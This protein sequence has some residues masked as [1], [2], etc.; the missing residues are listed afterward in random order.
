[1]NKIF[2]TLKNHRTG[3]ATAVSELQTGRTKGSGLSTTVL[4][5]ALLLALTDGAYAMQPWTGGADVS[6]THSNWNDH[7][8]THVGSGFAFGNTKLEFAAKTYGEEVQV[9][10]GDYAFKFDGLGEEDAPVVKLDLDDP[11]SLSVFEQSQGFDQALVHTTKLKIVSKPVS[12]S[13]NSMNGIDANIFEQLVEQN[14]E[15]VARGRYIIG[16]RAQ[17]LNSL[18]GKKWENHDSGIM[19]DSTTFYTATVL[20]ELDIYNGKTLELGVSGAQNW[21]AHL[22]GEG[23]VAYVGDTENKAENVV[24]IKQLYESHKPSEAADDRLH[25]AN[26]YDGATTVKNVTLNLERETSL[27]SSGI[28][29]ADNADIVEVNQGALGKLTEID[30]TNT[31]LKTAG[32]PLVVLGDATFAGANVLGVT[33]SFEVE[34]V[35]DVKS[36]SLTTGKAAFKAGTLELGDKLGGA[37]LTASSVKV[38]GNS[39]VSGTNTVNASAF[40]TNSLLLNET[41]A[42]TATG[43]VTATSADL[44]GGWISAETLSIDALA[45]SGANT[46]STENGATVTGDVNLANGVSLDVNRGKFAAGANVTVASGAKLHV[47][48]ALTVEETLTLVSSDFKK[49]D[50]NFVVVGTLKVGEKLAFEGNSFEDGVYAFGTSTSALNSAYDVSLTNANVEYESQL[51]GVGKT[52]LNQAHLTLAN[53]NASSLGKVVEMT[54]PSGSGKSRNLLT[55]TSENGF[56][57]IGGNF[58]VKGASPEDVIELSGSG[59]VTFSQSSPFG[60]ENEKY[61]GWIRMTG[62]SLDLTQTLDP[63]LSFS[64]GTGGTIALSGDQ[65]ITLKRLGWAKPTDEN[66]GMLDLSSFDFSNLASDEAAIS[67]DGLTVDGNGVIKLDQSAVSGLSTSGGSDGESIFDAANKADGKIKV[68]ATKSPTAQSGRIDVVLD[69]VSGSASALEGFFNADGTYTTDS[70]AAAAKGTWNYGTAFEDDGLYV[71]H[72]LTEVELLASQWLKLNLNTNETLGVV[73]TGSGTLEKSG[74]GELYLSNRDNTLSGE[75]RVAD[76]TLHAD[77]GALGS[78]GKKDGP[79]SLQ[80]ATNGTFLLTGEGTQYLKTLTSDGT[81]ELQTGDPDGSLTLAVFGKDSESAIGENSHLYGTESAELAVTEGATLR[82]KDLAN[83][84]SDYDGTIDV[85]GESYLELVGVRS[86]NAPADLSLVTGAGTVVLQ[87]RAT[88]TTK[89]GFTGTMQV[90][91]GGD[92]T[93]TKDANT[94]DAVLGMTAGKIASEGEHTFKEINFTGGTIHLGNYEAGDEKTS[95]MLHATGN[96]KLHDVTLEVSPDYSET[97]IDAT[98]ILTLDNTAGKTTLLL[99]GASVDSQNVTVNGI[100]DEGHES[101]LYQNGTKIG[102]ID[103]LLT[104]QIDETSVGVKAVANQINLTGTLELSVA[105]GMQGEDSTLDLI[106]NGKEPRSTV[107][108]TGGSV[109]LKQANSYGKLVVAEGAGVVLGNDQTLAAGGEVNGQVQTGDHNLVVTGGTLEV[110]KSANGDIGI[111]LD[112][113]ENG[114][115]ELL[116]ANRTDNSDVFGAT[117]KAENGAK[118]TFDNSRGK[119]A[120]A[121][122][123]AEYELRNGSAVSFKGVAANF[124]ADTLAV[125]SG[126]SAYYLFDG[127]ASSV[128]LSNVSGEG[129]VM[130]SYGQKGGMFDLTAVNGDFTGAIGVRNGTVTIGTDTQAADAEATAFLTREENAG[131]LLIGSGATLVVANDKTGAGSGNF[132]PKPVMLGKGASITISPEAVLDFTNGI[133]DSNDGFYGNT[134]GLSAN[135]IDMNGG[136]FIVADSTNDGHVSVKADI[137]AL[138]LS[139]GFND[140]ETVKKGS[141]LDLIGDNPSHPVLT[142]I[143]NIGGDEANLANIAGE[144]ELEL[145]DPDVVAEYWQPDWSG[146]GS[147]AVYVANVHTG[148]GLVADTANKGIAIGVGIKQI[149]VLDDQTLRIDPSVSVDSGKDHI[150]SAKIT[151]ENAS[152]SVTNELA[153][154][155]TDRVI[156]AVDNTYTGETKFGKNVKATARAAGAFATSSIVRLNEGAEL[157]LD[158]A[159]V[160]GDPDANAVVMQKLVADG[161]LVFSNGTD[162]LLTGANESTVTDKAT[163]EGNA[164]SVLR[165]EKGAKLAV[166]EFEDR[167]VDFEGSF[168]LAEGTTLAL[169]GEGKVDG[170]VAIDLSKVKGSGTI[171]LKDFAYHDTTGDFTG[172]TKVAEGG[173]LVIGGEDRFVTS[174]ANLAMTNGTIESQNEHVFDS[175]DL[176]GGVLNVGEVQAGADIASGALHGKSVNLENVTIKVSSDM[177]DVTVDASDI[178]TIDNVEGKDTWLVKGNEVKADKVTIEG[179]EEAEAKDSLLMQGD[180]QI[181]TIRHA[182]ELVTTDK[183]VGFKT[184]A[185][186]MNLTGTLNL[187]GSLD[188]T[189][190]TTLDLTVTGSDTG[191][192]H[193]A[194]ETVTID[195]ENSYGALQVDQNASVILNNTQTLAQGGLISGTVSGKGALAVTGGTLTVDATGSGDFAVE[196]DSKGTLA[197]ANRVGDPD[198]FK[199]VVNGQEGAVVSFAN[200][201]GNFQLASGTAG[202]VLADKS[203]VTFG[204]YKPAEN[205]S[206]TADT[207]SVDASSNAYFD[208]QGEAGATDLSK[209]SGEGRVVLGYAATPEAV[210]TLDVTAIGSDFTGTL[211]FTNAQATIGT[212]ESADSVLND[213]ATKQGSLWVGAGSVLHINNEKVR[214]ENGTVTPNPVKLAGDLTISDVATLDFM[215]GLRPGAGED[216]LGNV[217]GISVNSLD[218][219]THK[220]VIADNGVDDRV[221]LRVDLEDIDLSTGFQ[222]EGDVKG[223]ILDLM[224]GT[225]TSPVLTLIQG[226]DATEDEL[227]ALASDMRLVSDD[228]QDVQVEFWQPSWNPDVEQKEVHVANVHTGV[229]LVADTEHKGIAV[230]AGI[231]QIDI[232]SGATLRIDASASES[233]ASVVDASITSEDDKVKVLVTNSLGKAT[234]EDVKFL[235]ENTY[236]GETVI[237]LGAKATAGHAS[238]FAQ[239]KLVSVGTMGE[240]VNGIRLE[241]ESTL[242]LDTAQVEGSPYVNAVKMKALELG[243][244]GNLVMNADSTFA[245]GSTVKGGQSTS[246][247]LEKGKLEIADLGTLSDFKGVFRVNSDASVIFTVAGAETYTWANNVRFYDDTRSRAVGAGEFVKTGTGT[248]VIDGE[249]NLSLSAMNLVAAEGTTKF[250]GDASILGLTTKSGAVVDVDG[251]FETKNLTADAESVFKLDAVTGKTV[252]L[253]EG[254]TAT[255]SPIWGLDENGSDGIRVTGTASGTLNLAVTP[256]NVKKGAE[257]SI[258]L[259]DAADTKEGFTVNLVDE[260]GFALKALTAGAYDY[261]L[262]RKDDAQNGT[263]IFLSSIPGEDEKRNTTVTAGSYIGVAAAAQLFDISLHDRMSNRSWLTANADGSIANSFWVLETVSNERYGDSTGQIDVHDTASTTTVG[264]DILSGLAAGGTWYAGAMFSYATQDT[265]SRSN[266]TAL[267]SRADTDAWAAG[268]YAGWQ[269]NGADRTGPY[270]DGWILWTDAESDVKGVN[271]SETVDGNGLSASIEA[272]WGFKALSYNA[273]GQAGDIYVE[274]HVSVTWFGYEA[275]DVSN[276]VHDVTFEGKDNIRTKLGVKTYAF[277]KNSG[278]FSPYVELNWIHNTETYGVTM[279]NVTVEQVGAEDQGEVRAGADWRIND[280][281]TVWGH[282]GITSGSDGYSNREASLGV[283][284][285]F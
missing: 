1:M 206:F 114:T 279:S 226:I 229:K 267:E 30:F 7:G 24:T 58:S 87:D 22:T 50:P 188:Q 203:S 280:A 182:L 136:N 39:T 132:N 234:A 148:A 4:A 8:T 42:L 251:I 173:Y 85:G 135:A 86:D 123:T 265:K 119:F 12:F 151:G 44:K 113:G 181:G 72:T 264:S 92:L 88:Y 191:V 237:D 45:L 41:G 140:A 139:S 155:S 69:G 11:N 83:V 266:R 167:T 186:S 269:L 205:G 103:Y 218:L 111:L 190:D 175:I 227:K 37:E 21:G 26:N 110:G 130:L 124:A 201:T 54:P 236:T 46:I 223:S 180:E 274:P 118:V 255:K 284:Y 112:A 169:E 93:I 172:T 52:T 56:N 216:Y 137:D 108:V 258:Q 55:L 214:G 221:M 153:G 2:K 27:G 215:T 105:E 57:E 259:V 160:Q 219:N 94:A 212:D 73:M 207:V 107:S 170:H 235:A 16:T 256:K 277:G 126:S 272:G 70:E 230:G 74:T 141:I 122:G 273:H 156:F 109:T 176:T 31:M 166:T 48:D 147:G 183:G 98:N 204:P 75:V 276:D 271:V 238:A 161:T 25:L 17:N 145:E 178:L 64:V 244:N 79:A 144:M 18:T 100:T 220:L 96:I 252:A 233:D 10:L 38:T 245:E 225:E 263:D 213:F 34:G 211:A 65:S 222:P 154:A 189:A 29:T 99:E 116:F 150:L 239:S 84:A 179:L 184:R 283:R 208:V 195:K 104:A 158:T 95:G 177:K 242:V 202:Y 117:V 247:G 285:N 228:T 241:V 60:D 210:G 134:S 194:K 262:V 281:F 19:Y 168:R 49:D 63:D 157:E 35:A 76:G 82:I 133:T 224:A 217:S 115:A 278:G 13:V 142:L 231:T 51:Q 199:G 171:E 125:E 68:I 282:F 102:T 260:K 268:L 9:S 146:E 14:K 249:K 71:T 47:A 197:F 28:L 97:Q 196:L 248:L 131:S 3:A 257:E 209:I 59:A 246:I 127:Q 243:R 36:G 138:D 240:D 90:A 261:T 33:E 15:T 143:T 128:D 159:R 32:T 152:V 91:E 120:L 185:D 53:E 232:L 192:I 198:V 78:K 62:T 187:E 66:G 253:K 106:V 163:L 174:H 200:T 61:A 129:R 164:K 43:S 23:G 5:A 270:V 101:D 149:D 89:E 6:L 20:S 40:S 121:S 250:T 165:L 67:V 193:I 80:V 254:E 275:D 81:I 162:L 77:A